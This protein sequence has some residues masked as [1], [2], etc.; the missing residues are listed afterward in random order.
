MAGLLH[1]LVAE[2]VAG[3]VA[4]GLIPSL[5]TRTAPAAQHVGTSLAAYRVQAAGHALGRT[6]RAHGGV[7]TA[8]GTLAVSVS[9]AVLLFSG[10]LHP[11]AHGDRGVGPAPI[12]QAQPNDATSAPSPATTPAPVRDGSAA[13]RTAPAVAPSPL[14]QAAD[15]GGSSPHR[16]PPHEPPAQQPPATEPPPVDTPAPTPVPTRPP[17]VANGWDRR[18]PKKPDQGSHAGWSNPHPSRPHPGN[19]EPGNPHDA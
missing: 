2:G 3:A 5:A 17:G 12:V 7:A 9:A 16:P 11:H 10:A 6:L 18:P 1:A 14:V 4:W 15:D 13:R 19:P 8:A